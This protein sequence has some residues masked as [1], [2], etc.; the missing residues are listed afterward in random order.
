MN[1]AIFKFLI[2][3]VVHKLCLSKIGWHEQ[4]G[5]CLIF[6]FIAALWQIECDLLVS[7]ESLHK[8]YHRD[9]SKQCITSNT[10]STFLDHI[11]MCGFMRLPILSN[12]VGNGNSGWCPPNFVWNTFWYFLKGPVTQNIQCRHALELSRPFHSS[13]VHDCEAVLR[14]ALSRQ[15]MWPFSTILWKP[16]P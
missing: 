15:T 4:H 7:W 9:S 8:D 1:I 12:Q 13:T 3:P 5:N 10:V 16:L 2:I 6:T 14:Q 11:P